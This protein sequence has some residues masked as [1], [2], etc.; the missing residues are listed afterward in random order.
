[1][2]KL[3]MDILVSDQEK[4]Y[5]IPKSILLGVKWGMKLFFILQKMRLLWTISI[6]SKNYE[7]VGNIEK[8]NLLM[9]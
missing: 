8:F 4:D 6:G 1:M 3:T 5:D 9:I 2:E 7:L